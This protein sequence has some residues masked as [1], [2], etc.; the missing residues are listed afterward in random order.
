MYCVGHNVPARCAD[1][2]FS[3][4]I[5]HEL[6]G[7]LT[8]SLFIKPSSQ[9]YTSS[10]LKLQP[11]LLPHGTIHPRNI[12]LGTG[13]RLD[14]LQIP[15]RDL[16]GP[17][18][19]ARVL[20]QTHG[21]AKI[22]ARQVNRKLGLLALVVVAL[23]HPV[24]VFHHG[25]GEHE[26]QPLVVDVGTEARLIGQDQALGQGRDGADEEGVAKQLHHAGAADL[27]AA[28][29]DGCP[30]HDPRQVGLHLVNRLLW[31]RGDTDELPGICER[32]GAEDWAGN[33]LGAPSRQGLVD[34]ARCVWVD[35]RAV[36][37]ELALDVQVA[38]VN[39][40]L[41]YLLQGGIIADA[42]EDQVGGLDGVG[43]GGR[44][45]AVAQGLGESGGTGGGSVPKDQRGGE[46]AFLD[47]ILAHA[48][49]NG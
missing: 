33:E 32:G 22:L 42:A 26:L 36:D 47:D 24:G 3:N 2:Y 46:G 45:G 19:D 31:S 40:S 15:V 6:K 5:S 16:D 35:G 18:P 13:V 23:E 27:V 30:A 34:A 37:E 1:I 39:D 9:K 41:D 14:V 38:G 48:L 21:V 29:I 25:T 44:D 12:P 17:Q 11:R 7:C 4:D 10:I 43:D 49:F 8:I 28:H 20:A